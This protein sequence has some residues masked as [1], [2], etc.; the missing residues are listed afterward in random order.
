MKSYIYQHT[1]RIIGQY[2]N[3]R[4]VL[5]IVLTKEEEEEVVI[6]CKEMTNMG[7]GLDLIQLKS[8]MAQICQSMINPFKDGFP[9]KSWW[10]SF[11][12]R[13]LIEAFFK[14]LV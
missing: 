1:K 2:Q 10:A 11:K 14:C 12:A 6:W 5:L 4:R 3:K 8:K 9:G 13:I 7:N